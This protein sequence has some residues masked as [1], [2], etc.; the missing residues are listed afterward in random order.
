MGEGSPAHLHTQHGF[1][2][3]FREAGLSS[4]RVACS[5][6][7]TGCVASLVAPS[8]IAMWWNLVQFG[9]GVAGLLP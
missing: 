5:D 1:S 7:Q 2:N 3:S 9:T 8:S 4:T 6:S